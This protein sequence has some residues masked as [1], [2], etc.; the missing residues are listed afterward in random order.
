MPSIE[1]EIGE[2]E[3]H[4]RCRQADLAAGPP[5]LLAVGRYLH[6]LVEEAEIHADIGKHRPGQRRGRR[7]HRGPLDHEQDRQEQ[8]QQAGNADNDAAKQRVGIDGVLVGFRLPQI[9][10]RQ[11]RRGELGHER[12][13]RPRIERHQEDVGV[14]ARLPVERK[15]LA[16]RDVGNAF[17]AEVRPEQ[18]GSDQP[19]MRCDDQPVELLVAAVGEREHRPVA[20]R[21]VVIGLD[22][23]APDDAVGPGRG[24]YLE[25]FALVAVDLDGL[26]Q[27]ERDVVAR[28][29]DRLDC[30][31]ADAPNRVA[32]IARASA[33]NIWQRSENFKEIRPISDRRACCRRS[34]HR[35]NDPATRH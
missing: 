28:N 29:L 12:H 20:V 32:A 6:D 16:R 7:E 3:H 5:Y 23:D 35:G 19:E 26:R 34:G 14:D 27:V 15:T 21:M 10:L 22:L 33:R 4:E 1:V 30:R 9:D 31:R 24:R 8:R 17:G 11:L 25:I 13:H 18:P 2:Q